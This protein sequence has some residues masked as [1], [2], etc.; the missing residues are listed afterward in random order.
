MALS[1]LELHSFSTIITDAH[2]T[3][4]GRM[5]LAEI[6]APHWSFDN[7]ALAKLQLSILF[8]RARERKDVSSEKQCHKGHLGQRT[9]PLHCY[10]LA[11][12]AR[13]Q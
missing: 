4:Q 9:D 11:E 6:L 13:G 7:S 1:L 5:H 2:A 12:I 3:L 8:E 10:R